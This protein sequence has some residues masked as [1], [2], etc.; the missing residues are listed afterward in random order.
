MVLFALVATHADNDL[1]TVARL[2]GGASGVHG[3]AV[4]LATCNRFEL[5]GSSTDPA[6]AAIGLLESLAESTGMEQ[7]TL[8]S[9]FRLLHGS[10][11][12]RHLFAVAAGLDSA[13]VG[14]REIAGQV[15]RALIE[16]QSRF[17]VPGP[18]AKLFQVAS[19]TAKK[20]GSD[21][22]LGSQGR[23]V[24]SVALEMTG[25]TKWTDQRAVVHGTGAYAGATVALLKERGVRE[26]AVYSPSGRAPEFAAA[27]GLTAVESLT[28][29][30]AWATLAVGCSGSEQRV[31]LEVVR[32]A[33][34]RSLAGD[35][36]L[37]V[38][39][40]AL[41]H[42]FDPAIGELPGV[43]LLS[44]ES[45]RLAA[46]AEQEA[47]VEQARSIVSDAAADFDLEQAKRSMDSA[48]V[49][50]RQHTLAVLDVELERVRTQ[51]GCTAA[52]EEV[53]FA[54]RRMVKQLLH[55]PTVRA[56]QLAAEGRGEEFNAALEALYGIGESVRGLADS[57]VPSESE[58]SE[59]SGP[60]SCPVE[61]LGHEQSA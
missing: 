22:A 14:E 38:I 55:V 43:E 56:K 34:R 37:T 4:V 12:P 13:V 42:D 11:V 8:E 1:E 52:A 58:S 27:R 57:A 25:R 18:T 6:A 49:A 45:V 61:R 54:L 59:S 19:R 28:D 16:A 9:H 5:Y 23:S 10:A 17:A 40:L 46:P 47:T 15:R 24:V 39:D 35:E 3:N 2:S 53:E 29:A 31:S 51:H 21:T 20:V 26:I 44:L 36:P 60:E 48:I 32:D 30:L 41:T 7:A 50:L 33:R